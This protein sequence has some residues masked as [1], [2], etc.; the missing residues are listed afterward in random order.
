M[1]SCNRSY[2]VNVWLKRITS[3]SRSSFLGRSSLTTIRIPG[4]FTRMESR[5]I[6]SSPNTWVWSLLSRSLV[7][8]WRRRCEMVLCILLVI[9]LDTSK[10][11]PQRFRSDPLTFHSFL[12]SMCCQFESK[13]TRRSS[14]S[15]TLA[16]LGPDNVIRDGASGEVLDWGTEGVVSD[17]ELVASSMLVELFVK[18][19]LESEELRRVVK[20]RR[21]SPSCLSKSASLL[22][23]EVDEK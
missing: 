20:L 17:W 8:T 7:P 13:H 14:S 3:E 16:P 5:R 1:S 15:S 18:E 22:P 11:V 2:S 6:S 9:T 19:S 12:R 10:S 23:Y 4:N 21:S